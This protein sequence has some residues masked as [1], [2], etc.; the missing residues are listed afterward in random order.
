ML[1]H[2]HFPWLLKI[3]L[4]CGQCFRSSH[5][6]GECRHQVGCLC[7]SRVGHLAARC[8]KDLKRSPHSKRL[9]VHSKRMSEVSLVQLVVDQPMVE[10]TVPQKSKLSRA[11]IS[12]PLSSKIASNREELSKVAILS[13]VTGFV[14]VKSILELAHSLINHPLAGLIT[15]MNDCHFLVPLASREVVKEV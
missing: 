15:L 6:M 8:H 11:A 4:T 2:A 3:P 14:N 1:N 10:T 9:Q 13:I 12:I 5:L 7:C